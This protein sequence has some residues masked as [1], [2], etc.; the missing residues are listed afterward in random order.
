MLP[1]GLIRALLRKLKNY[2]CFSN[3]RGGWSAW[4]DNQRNKLKSRKHSFVL[5]ISQNKHSVLFS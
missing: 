5:K 3:L 4:I 1:R 2:C